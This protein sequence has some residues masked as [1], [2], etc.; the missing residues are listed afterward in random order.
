M[1]L[2]ACIYMCVHVI[3]YNINF[4]EAH[5]FEFNSLLARSRLKQETIE[6]K[7]RDKVYPN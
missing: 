7:K 1:E 5:S 6:W 2:C 3:F 4:P